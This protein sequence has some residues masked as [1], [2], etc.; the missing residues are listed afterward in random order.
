MK[1]EVRHLTRI[2]GHAHLVIDTEAGE[3]RECRLEIVES[4]RFFEEILLGRH[5]SD[6]APLVS[7]ICGVCSNSHTLVSLAATEDALGMEISDQTRRLRQLL[8]AGEVLQS[9]LLHL[10]FMASP[11]Y[12]GVASLFALAK[13]HRELVA[14]ALRLKKVAND[15]CLCVG[16]RS[17]HPVSPCVGGFQMLPEASQLRSLRRSLVGAL[18]DLE[19][20]I[21]LWSGFE[22]P[23][24]HRPVHSLSLSGQGR[25]PGQ[26]R[27]FRA[28][29]GEEFPV[30]D[31]PDQI[32]EYVVPHSTA[33]FARMEGG[34]YCVGPLARYRNGAAHLSPMALKVAEALGLPEQPQNPYLGN[35]ARMVEVVHHLEEAIHLIDELLMA[36]LQSEPR[37]EPSR[38]GLGRAGIEAP[39]GTLFHGYRYDEQGLLREMDCLIPTAQNLASIEADLAALIPQRLHLDQQA[40]TRELEMLVRA[41]DPCI[42]CSTHLLDVRFC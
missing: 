25:Y 6:V 10:F 11:D 22:T 9:H 32:E 38:F 39:R 29:G 20:A 2:E 34:S 31:Y 16:G 7:R 3:L 8:L 27:H 42:S 30:A 41:Y 19:E 24:F 14:R 17:I 21:E 5:Y 1:I 37:P 15:I 40:I 23:E 13:T 28:S 35:H 36:G 18:P 4:P 33:L 12:L 26:Q